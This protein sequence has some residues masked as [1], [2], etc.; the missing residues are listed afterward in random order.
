MLW[1]LTASS[2][3]SKGKKNKQT[4]PNHLLH[5]YKQFSFMLIEHKINQQTNKK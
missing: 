1:E 2:F 5:S 3:Q 4:K